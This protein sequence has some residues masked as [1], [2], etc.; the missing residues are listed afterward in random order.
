MTQLYRANGVL[1]PAT[2]IEIGPCPVIA[3]KTAD[4]KDR[5]NALKLG[6][7]ESEKITKPEKGLFAKLNLPGMKVVKEFRID[8]PSEFTVG[9][10]LKADVFKPGEIVTVK[11]TTKGRGFASVI[12]RH[13]FSGGKE[14]HGC[15]AKR[16]PGSLGGSSDPSRVFKGKKLPGH[17]GDT[18]YTVRG[19][20]VLLVD[21]E[22]NV[23]FLKGAV[24]GARNGFVYVSKQS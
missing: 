13:G 4:G 5:Y 17:Y 15:R 18:N 24:P 23:I 6:F 1:C 20:E 21:P 9:T 10:V 7:R 11:G 16:I 14:T 3:V 2:A 19:L 22:K 8:N 12:K